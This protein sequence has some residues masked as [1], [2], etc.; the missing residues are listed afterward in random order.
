MSD[1]FDVVVVGGG[2]AGAM[3]AYHLAKAGVRTAVLDASAFPRDKTCGGGL[4]QRAALHIPFDWSS[5]NRGA[6][7]SVCFSFRCGRR[8]R[9]TCSDPLVYGILRSEF[10]ALLL[11]QARA[12][13]ADVRE[14]SKALA[15]GDVSAE[16]TAVETTQGRIEGRFVVGADG[17]NSVVRQAVARRSDYFWN[18]A[19]SC[20]VPEQRLR[21]GVLDSHT[22]R[23]DWGTM[24]GYGW[25]F[26][27]H[28]F[29]NI[30]VGGPA[31]VGRKLRGFLKRFVESE[32]VLEAGEM[33]GLPFRGHQ[34][35]TLRRG[36]PLSRGN[37]LLA[38]DA[39]GLVDPLTGDGISFGLHSAHIASRTL[40]EMLNGEQHDIAVYDRRVIDEIA[41]ELFWSQ[42]LAALLVAFPRVVHGTVH[43]AGRF[44][45]A[46]C[47][48]M[49]G[50]E[51]LLVFRTKMLPFA[52]MLRWV[53]PLAARRGA[54]GGT[55]E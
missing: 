41:T 31:V 46:F 5:A 47:H 55:T 26:P 22:A 35:P 39:A 10:D 12:A 51:S 2:P 50:E 21:P 13:G 29:V 28:K 16:R 1:S 48:V 54:S 30:G 45:K 43:Y 9:K 40:L 32:R 20:E 8:F 11:E 4:Q 52:P 17:A 14:R 3:T 27:K 37:V 34:L 49:R 53:E 24:P 7:D 19:L 36:T 15:V 33:A 44:W 42:R 38:G 25:M 6:M 23:I 18:V